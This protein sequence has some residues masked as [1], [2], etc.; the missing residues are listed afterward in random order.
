[1]TQLDINEALDLAKD[2]VVTSGDGTK[3]IKIEDLKGL[4]R[5]Q[6]EEKATDQLVPR[7]RTYEQA[8]ALASQDPELREAFADRPPVIGP[9]PPAA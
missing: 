9:S 6:A 3:W 8:K 7:P 2:L 1:M 4:Q 5:K